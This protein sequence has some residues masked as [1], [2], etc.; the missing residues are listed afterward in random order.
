MDKRQVILVKDLHDRDQFQSNVA[1]ETGSSLVI[2]EI[3]AVACINLFAKLHLSFGPP[4]CI[5]RNASKLL[6]S[7]APCNVF[8]LKTPYFAFGTA[9]LRLSTIIFRPARLLIGTLKHYD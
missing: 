9:S 1:D 6:H 2:Q 5:S 4:R 8:L 3:G 7:E